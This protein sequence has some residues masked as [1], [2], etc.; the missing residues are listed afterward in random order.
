MCKSRARVWA[1]LGVVTLLSACGGGG[2][3]GGSTGAGNPP[4]PSQSGLL[5]ATVSYANGTATL[6]VLDADQPSA[7]R[8]TT[9]V[10]DHLIVGGLVIDANARTDTYTGDTIVY[11]ARAGQL[12]QMSLRKGSSN[13]AQRISS[14]TAACKVRDWHPLRFDGSDDAWI[15]I[16]EAGFDRS[17]AQASDNRVGYVRSGASTTTAPIFLPT[18]VSMVESLPDPVSRTLAGF[19][20]IDS[21]GGGSKLIYY[22]SNLALLGDVAGGAGLSNLEFLSF[23]PGPS[24]DSSA[25]VLT[26]LELRRLTWSASGASLSAPLYAYIDYPEP[27][28]FLDANAM[29]FVDGRRVMRADAAGSVSPL[30]E[31]SAATAGRV[32]LKGLTSGHVI[33]E[34]HGGA[35]L[36]AIYSLSKSGGAPLPIVASGEISRA[37]GVN[38]DDVIYT[39][40][41]LFEG[42][43]SVRRIH[44]GGANNRVITS[45]AARWPSFV[46][47]PAFTYYAGFAID[48]V[49]W[50]EPL[51]PATECRN[52][53][54][55]SFDLGTGVATTLGSIPSS[56]S[57]GSLRFSGYSY[58]GQPML[59]N[60]FAADSSSNATA[61]DVYLMRPGGAGSL[62]RL[63]TTIP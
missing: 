43:M 10:D 31:L 27:G 18:G 29:Y 2:D 58:T 63:T 54:V 60:Y 28:A 1:L 9:L 13:A 32:E 45:A 5:S 48:A 52:G 55:R 7:T 16:T 53:T 23:R 26:A 50:C 24:L 40:E 14:T 15:E 47:R 35:N 44:A 37:M 41:P 42:P 62:L 61:N 6:T 51:S 20:A 25:L 57:P 4:P 56:S 8:T 12:F 30:G 21:R 38:G 3:Q 49:V 36:S 17:C 34:A 11:Y 19:V 33:F 59:V 46:Y 22:S 39:V